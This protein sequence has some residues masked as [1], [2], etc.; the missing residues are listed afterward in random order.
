[1]KHYL[2]LRIIVLPETNGTLVHM[3]PEGA[4]LKGTRM[5]LSLLLSSSSLLSLPSPSSLPAPLSCGSGTTFSTAGSR[6]ATSAT[7]G[8]SDPTSSPTLRLSGAGG[9]V[10]DEPSSSLKRH[11]LMGEAMEAVVVTEVVAVFF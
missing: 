4:I 3:I 9:K 1:M 11:L 2:D 7:G 8:T 5:A 10:E 6:T